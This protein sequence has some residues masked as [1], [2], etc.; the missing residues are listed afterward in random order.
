MIINYCFSIIAGTRIMAFFTIVLA[1]RF[2][3]L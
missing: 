3:F 2:H 1:Y